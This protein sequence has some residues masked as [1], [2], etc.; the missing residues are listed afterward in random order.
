M[1]RE[2]D[3]GKLMV[4][5]FYAKTQRS[6]NKELIDRGLAYRVGLDDRSSDHD[7][8]ASV[9]SIACST[10]GITVYSSYSYF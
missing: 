9:V 6:L 3:S 5:L 10:E 8:S 7:S 4:E 2:S 1:I